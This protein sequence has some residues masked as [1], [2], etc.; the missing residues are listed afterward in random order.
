MLTLAQA[1]AIES[2]TP[3]TVDY[4]TFKLNADGKASITLRDITPL[5]PAVDADGMPLCVLPARPGKSIHLEPWGF[6]YVDAPIRHPSDI[7]EPPR[8][9]WSERAQARPDKP[10][11]END[12]PAPRG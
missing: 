12:P 1:A 8:F 3:R 5:R 2:N 4:D 6:T 11:P 10:T 7:D 9:D